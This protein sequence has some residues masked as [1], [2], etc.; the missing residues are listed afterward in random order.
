M[1][2]SIIFIDGTNLDH[3]LWDF[4]GRD[5]VH[6]LKFFAKISDGTQLDRVHYCTAPYSRYG[7]QAKRA[8]QTAD[9]NFLRRQSN[10]TLH[11]GR[12]QQRPVTCLNCNHQYQSFKEKGTDILVATR[13]VDAAFH[14][15]AD[16]LILVSNDNDFWPALELARQHGVEIYTAFVVDPDRPTG[17]QLQ[18]LSPLRQQA[19]GYLTVDDAFMQDCWRV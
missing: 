11:L 2:S 13:F 9:F 17:D 8:K 19:H 15:R 4:F 16:R 18:R 12:F 14:K 10:V 7:N 6:F 1:A 3:R 5:D